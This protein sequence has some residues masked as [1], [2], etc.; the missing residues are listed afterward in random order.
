MRYALILERGENGGWGAYCPDLEGLVIFGQTKEELLRVAP[1]AIQEFLSELC[2][3]GLAPPK[4]HAEV[5]TVE[6][7]A[8]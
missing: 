4:P 2:R 8:A 7:P 5:A 6:V 1:D 3:D